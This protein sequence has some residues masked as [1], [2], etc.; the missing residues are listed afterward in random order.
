[1][2]RRKLYLGLAGGGVAAVVIGLVGWRRS[3]PPRLGLDR[4]RLVIVAGDA[5]VDATPAKVAQT[6]ASGA[7]V[8]T[9]HGNACFSVHASR[10]C[11]GGDSE[12]HL[13]ELGTS[14]AT[15][16]VKRG[17]LVVAS[18][19]DE[20]R[21]VLPAGAVVVH[22]GT[23]SIED[24]GGDAVVRALDGNADLE[25]TG[26]PPSALASPGVMALRDGRKRPSSAAV[27]DEE[28]SV[29]ALARRWQGTAGA[30]VEVDSLHGRVEVD[31]AI[32][33]LA[34]AAVLL[35]EGD[36]TLV[37]REGGRETSHEALRLAAGQKVVR[38]G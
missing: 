9:G 29:A 32:V 8:H 17:A 34:P 7:I 25:P 5:S 33:G 31:G 20:L 22:G 27:E 30:V 24:A 1:M 13:A 2:Q 12:A 16:E 35:D 3:Q 19:G 14:S 36:H 6:L 37:I 11:L 21:I 23:L 26:R 10:V 15:I 4:P 18:A 38:G 28:R